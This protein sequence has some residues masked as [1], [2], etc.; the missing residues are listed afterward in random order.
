MADPR[1]SLHL[2]PV[3]VA[4]LLAGALPSCTTQAP[5][6]QT[7]PNIIFLMADDMG[8]GDPGSFNEQSKI[9]T[10]HM[11][12][13]AAGGMR[14]TDAH[15]GSAVCTPTR[16]GV[17]TGRYAWRSPL[18]RGV[19]SGYS[20]AL[21][22]PERMTV[23][24]M[25]RDHGYHTAVVGK[26][27]LG[28]DW[29][30]LSEP[31]SWNEG[32]T[33][34]AFQGAQDFA[35]PEG[36]EIDF[37]KPVTN[38]PATLGFD[39]SYIIP[40]SLDMAPYVYLENNVCEK[41]ATV[42][43]PGRFDGPVFWRPGEAAEGFDFFDVLPNLTRH[44]IDYIE[45]RSEHPDR[46]FFLY[47]PLP[48][49]HW[50][51]V[52]TEEYVGR[53][54]AGKYGDFVM[55]VDAQIGLLAD[56]LKRTGQFENTLFIVT[57]DNGA[58]WDPSHIEDFGHE[59]NH[60]SL[61]GKKRDIWEGGHRMP[62]IASWPARVAAGST[63]DQTICLTDLM[64][65]AAEIVG[66]ALPEEAG[67]D[68]VSVLP[69]LLGED[70]GALREATVH[71]SVDGTFAIRQGNWKYIDGQGPGSNQWDGPKDGDPPAQLYDTESDRHEDHNLFLDHPEVA[72]R[73]KALL[74]RYKDQGHS[75]SLGPDSP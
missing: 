58:E 40:A 31:A 14:F 73:L 5:E 74:E 49:P 9:A 1:R 54:G 60:P 44:A 30:T 17:V 23:A 38:G 69:A 7:A 10:P 55:Q 32:D 25:L 6:E 63:S 51:W 64:A 18:K 61:R 2:L 16:Y 52:P 56:A 59:A 12:S 41:P 37:T 27:H 11:D 50:P 72:N 24:S 75:R 35:K 71:H 28:L 70:S 15:S 39:Y 65:T 45:A 46:P 22:E 67:Q 57:S 34:A 42:H 4:A 26:W 43:E 53:S 48:A 66:Y 33:S 47:Y 36:L 21:I 8:Y 68:S 62:F 20:K 3:L 13:L 19:L 29:A